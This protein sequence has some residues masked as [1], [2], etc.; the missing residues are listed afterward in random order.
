MGGTLRLDSGGEIGSRRLHEQ[1]AGGGIGGGRPVGQLR[2]DIDGPVDHLLDRRDR[3][4]EPESLGLLGRHPSVGEG[5][6]DRP[7]QPDVVGQ[8]PCRACVGDEGES[9]ESRE[10]ER[11]VGHHA[12][13]ASQRQ[14]HTRPGGSA[15]DGSDGRE[16]RGEQ[17]LHH[18]VES[19][20]DDAGEVGA[21][22]LV[23][24]DQVRQV[25][26]RAEG[27]AGAGDHHRSRLVPGPPE[28]VHQAVAQLL[29]DRI[30]PVGAVEGQQ[31]HITLHLIAHRHGARVGG[32]SPVRS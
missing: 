7:G 2:G 31:G 15:V 4:H 5:E 25:R 3:R 1:S 17:R 13:V 18:R 22:R 6:F 28:T 12:Q 32:V 21:A 29:C 9:Y 16:W 24:P 11:R 19:L 8:E 14:S 10:E 27:L 30:E 23:F 20:V 26:P